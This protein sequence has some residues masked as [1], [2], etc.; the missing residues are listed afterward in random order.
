MNKTE[1]TRTIS[2]KSGLTIKDAGKFLDAFTEAA[3]TALG[4]GEDVILVGFGSFSRTERKARIARN[5]QTGKNINIPPSKSVKFRPG[6]NLKEKVN[7]K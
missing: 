7:R 1:L 2:E 6:K 3:T 5:F 4:K